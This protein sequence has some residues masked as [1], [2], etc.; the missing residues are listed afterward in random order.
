MPTRIPKEED[1]ESLPPALK[2]ILTYPEVAETTTAILIVFHGLGDGE[3][4]FSTFA[5]NTKLPGVLAITVRGVSPLPPA[6]LG[7][8]ESEASQPARHFHWGDDL[9]IT[10]SSGDLDPD[11]GYA[12][13]KSLVMD[14]LI[15]GILI[16]KC[17]WE[18]NDILLFGYG[19]GGTLALGLASKLRD[20]EK[21]VDVTD[22]DRT[23]ETAFKG[24]VSIGGPLPSSMIPTTSNREKA[25]TPVLICHGR[26]SE[27]VGD[28]EVDLMKNEFVDVREVKWQKPEDRMPESREE[29]LP[30]MQFFAER[31]DR[32]F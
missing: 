21:V 32:S 19:Q 8:P 3:E 16:E 6:L 29:M 24:V 1:F 30:I 13:A 2:V 4:N 5:K 7:L 25:R 11:P 26:A 15:R 18:T 22:G 17:G 20:T 14:E 31:L 23:P 9:T 27:L 12:K 28:E 10:S